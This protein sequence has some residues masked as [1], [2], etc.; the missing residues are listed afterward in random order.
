MV[1]MARQT[2][3]QTRVNQF[4]ATLEDE[5][6]L[7]DTGSRQDKLKEGYLNIS[8]TLAGWSTR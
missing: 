7:G 8:V 1:D 4:L 5:G 6:C 3:P 2:N